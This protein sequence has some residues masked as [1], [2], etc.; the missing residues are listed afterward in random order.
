MP[1]LRPDFPSQKTEEKRVDS[2][3]YRPKKDSVF[4]LSKD[5]REDRGQ[6][7]RKLG[8]RKGGRHHI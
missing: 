2:P 7:Q 1:N 6:R 4:S 8:R 5:I 3:I